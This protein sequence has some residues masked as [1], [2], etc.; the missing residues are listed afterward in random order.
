MGLLADGQQNADGAVGG[1]EEIA[2]ADVD[3]LR[4]QCF[5]HLGEIKQVAVLAHGAQVAVGRA[6]GSLK[7][8]R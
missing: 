6:F 8:R 4:R 3:I 2:H 1:I 5:E 7:L